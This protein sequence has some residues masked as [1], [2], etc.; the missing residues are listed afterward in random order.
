M[1]INSFAI[2]SNSSGPK[3]SIRG[4]PT[5]YDSYTNSLTF[6]V[7]SYPKQWVLYGASTNGGG[8]DYIGES[9]YAVV[10]AYSQNG[11]TAE[12]FAIKRYN[13]NGQAQIIDAGSAISVSYSNSKFTI[14]TSG[15]YSFVN[16]REYV[17]L[18]V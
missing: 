8:Y 10:S 17:L 4:F 1:I 12:C 15:K 16:K 2:N 13:S 6:D 5:G 3:Q 11:L 18:Y 14:E 7:D 9:P